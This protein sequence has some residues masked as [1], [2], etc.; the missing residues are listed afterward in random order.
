MP[1]RED[2]AYDYHYDS[3]DPYVYEGTSTLINK[4]GLTNPIE[5]SRIEKAITGAAIASLEVTPVVGKYDL[6]HLQAIHK[7]LF[8]EIYEWAG[9]IRRKGF[10]SKGNSLFCAAEYIE[11][12]S[13]DL[14]GKLKSENFLR[15]LDHEAFADR[16]AFYIAEI[17]ALHPFREGNGRTQRVFIDQLSR[18]AG[19]NLNLT[20]IEP[21]LVVDA[22]ITSM[23]DCSP[24][25]G[26]LRGTIKQ[27]AA[28]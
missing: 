20:A 17:N 28:L 7:A 14:F 9:Q 18:Q 16:I 4:F 21:E 3:D 12:Y 8:E 26:L 15:D 5:L 23:T 19:W 1:S 22:Y 6:K 11:P 25:A 13:T 2:Q 10:I 24:L 27:L